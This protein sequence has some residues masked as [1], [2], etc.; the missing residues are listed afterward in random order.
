MKT[1]LN[2]RQQ[3]KV[4]LGEEGI[5]LGDL[6]YVKQGQ[7]ENTA[8]ACQPSWLVAPAVLACPTVHTG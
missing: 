2:I 4:C 5:A 1:S 8:F 6:V 3:V 7:R